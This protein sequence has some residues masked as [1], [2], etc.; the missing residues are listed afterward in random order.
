MD[1]QTQPIPTELESFVSEL[2]DQRL[3]QEKQTL[4]S[5]DREA[6]Q[7]VLIDQLGVFMLESVYAELPEEK[8]V[9]F[10]KLIEEKKTIEELRQYAMDHIPNYAD[11]MADVMLDFEDAYLAGELDQANAVETFITE[12]IE[13][14]GF[15]NLTQEQ[16][17]EIALD[18]QKRLD[19][20]IMTRTLAQFSE[21]EIAEF[22]QLLSGKKSRAE[23]QQFAMGH[24]TDYQTFM[25]NTLLAFQESYLS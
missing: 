13:K 3:E 1:I 25:T 14:K 24:I 6:V 10:K 21:E 17:G 22:N 19:E 7:K 15:S 11:F 5:K 8:Q 4:D 9:I 2:I 18:I 12:L 23:L 16:H 20:F